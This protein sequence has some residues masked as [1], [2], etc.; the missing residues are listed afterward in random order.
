LLDVSALEAEAT[1][2]GQ[3]IYN[4]PF[5]LR[6]SGGGLNQ[7]SEDGP[8]VNIG[9]AMNRLERRDYFP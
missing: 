3:S 9:P 6:Y 7:F 8:G 2:Y 1:N 4:Q 5:V